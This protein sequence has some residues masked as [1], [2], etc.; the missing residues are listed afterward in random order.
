MHA[1]KPCLAHAGLDRGRV[2]AE[3]EAEAAVTAARE[4]AEQQ[5]EQAQFEQANTVKATRPDGD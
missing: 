4:A 2:V 5:Q 1:A 3:K